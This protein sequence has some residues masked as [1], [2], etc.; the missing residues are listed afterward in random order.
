MFHDLLACSTAEKAEKRLISYLSL[1]EQSDLVLQTLL[2]SGQKKSSS[3]SLR[4]GT[5]NGRLTLGFQATDV[6]ISL[7]PS[8]GLLIL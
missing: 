1:A 6:R 4:G 5:L 7:F 3:C 8:R 2:F